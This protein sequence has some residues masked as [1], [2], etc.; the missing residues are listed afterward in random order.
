MVVMGID[1]SYTRTGISIAKD[2]ELINVDSID[3]KK[4]K[5]KTEKRH[6][7]KREINIRIKMYK[8]DIIIVER[9]RQ[10][11]AGGKGSFMSMNM[12]KAGTQLI[13]SIIDI[14]YKYKIP[15]YSVDTRSWKS[16]IV[17]TSKYKGNN[18]KEPT[19]KYV[20]SLGF[21]VGTND[22]A[23]DSACIALYGFVDSKNKKLKLEE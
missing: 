7:I 2:N 6:K 10:F 13:T 9:V 3:F 21:D 4:I 19:I 18:K 11:S 8:P 1:Q 16:Q 12:I 23:A 14:A 22:D 17:G 15:V 20:N 5:T